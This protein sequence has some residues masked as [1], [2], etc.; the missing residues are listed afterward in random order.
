[1]KAN[2]IKTSVAVLALIVVQGVLLGRIHLFGCATPLLLVYVVIL[3]PLNTPRWASLLSGFLLGIFS[4]AFTNTPGVQAMTLTA[5][6]F[7]QPV[8]L[9]LMLPRDAAENFK[10]SKS[11]LGLS[12]FL[13]YSLVLTLLSCALT[14][15]LED[16]SSRLPLLLLLNILGS[17]I[18]TC[19]LIFVLESIR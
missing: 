14:F 2:V 4:D 6:A 8:L 18:L 5:V 12:K 10:P 15:L 1:M 17:T 19:L 13:V 3:L 11:S 7:V 9:R 16:F